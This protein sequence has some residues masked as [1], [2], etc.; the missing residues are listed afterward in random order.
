[1]K[2]D[3][4]IN[5]KQFI[6]GYL[7][8]FIS[9]AIIISFVAVSGFNYMYSRH[10]KKIDLF[11]NLEIQL[12][13]YDDI[14]ESYLTENSAGMEIVD[15]NLRVLKSKGIA[16]VA[17]YQY[18]AIS[19]AELISNQQFNIKA[20]Y[21]SIEENGETY[22]V[23]LKQH[24]TKKTASKVSYLS[25]VYSLSIFA[26]IIIVFLIIFYTFVRTIYKRIKTAFD[27]I[28]ANISKTPHDKSKVDL[29]AIKLSESYSVLQAYNNMLDELEQI[30]KEKDS[31]LRQNKTLISNLSHD[32]KSP[33]TTLK[34]YSELLIEEELSPIQQKDYLMYIN[35]RASDLSELISLLF[36]QVKFQH[37]DFS[38]NLEKEDMN[39]FLRDLCANYYMIFDKHGFDVNIEIDE[40]PHIMEFDSTNMK[41]AFC[42]LFENCL[43]HNKVPT[44]FEVSTFMKNG[45]YFIQFKDDGIG[46][47]KENKDRIFEP[48]FQGDNSRSRN[49]GGL[50]L[51]V[52][53]QIIEK[54]G[55]EITLKSEP[56][57]KTVFEMQ[58]KI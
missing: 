42:N 16:E 2:K 50:G 49:H 8:I 28:E 31:I 56:D 47:P 3:K 11:E 29:S 13:Q 17:G 18:S 43:S 27:L 4:R 57:Y 45:V 33:I 52:T 35:Q 24:F 58:F 51:F 55:G 6:S 23:L 25:S 22:T 48:F 36:E 5:L 37:P 10:I 12:K 54:H 30:R 38:L 19:F 39:S 20:T 44:K 7:L 21:Q 53:K 9:A 1:M 14:S 26:T 34:G 41:R 46:V 32:L 15:K 40:T